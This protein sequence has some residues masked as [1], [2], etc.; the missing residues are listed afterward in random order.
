[1]SSKLCGVRVCVCVRC[2]C[3]CSCLCACLCLCLC[4]VFVFVF[5]FVFGVSEI[6]CVCVCVCRRLR[7]YDVFVSFR[8]CDGWVCVCVRIFEIMFFEIMGVRDY[9]MCLCSVS[10]R[11]YGVFVFGSV[12][13][14]SCSSKLCGVCV[15][16]EIIRRNCVVC[17]FVVFVFGVFIVFLFAFGINSNAFT[18]LSLVEV[19]LS[20][21]SLPRLA[22]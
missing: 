8:F 18:V 22:S 6:V 16:V 2:L 13:S 14:R 19:G 4:S 20:F 17:V 5:V 15:C 9:V 11:F 7:D 12:S 21:G 1:M 10:S 3:G